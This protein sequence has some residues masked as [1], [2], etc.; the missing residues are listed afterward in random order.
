M[1]ASFESLALEMMS[2]IQRFRRPRVIAD[3][4]GVVAEFGLGEDE[5]EMY[6]RFHHFI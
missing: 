1:G 4:G 6:K 5:A 2:E 3:G